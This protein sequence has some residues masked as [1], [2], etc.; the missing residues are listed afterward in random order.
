[1]KKRRIIIT[2]FI[3]CASLVI[4]I[5]YATITGNLYINGT[6]TFKG[7]VALDE[8][9]AV[10][11]TASKTG[12]NCTDASIDTSD[13]T[14]ANITVVFN[15]TLGNAYEFTGNA[16][17]KIS[18]N[19]DDETLPSVMLNNPTATV[20]AGTA[21]KGEF[22]ITATYSPDVNT[23][24]TGGLVDTSTNTVVLKPGQTVDVMVVVK[25]VNANDNGE[26][27]TGEVEA[28]IAVDFSYST[29]S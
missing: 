24:G 3:L 7:S 20:T 17:Y 10:G 5:G 4:G 11:F 29:I 22:T 25:Y 9:V 1:M 6:A 18:Y 26:I 21:N 16:T 15:D 23:S 8:Q 13:K 27:E 28:T 19:A 12:T 14:K 2:A